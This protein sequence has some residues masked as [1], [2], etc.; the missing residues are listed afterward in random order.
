MRGI[1]S[2]VEQAIVKVIKAQLIAD[3]LGTVSVNSIT[4]GAPGDEPVYPYVH[5]GCRP[6]AHKGALI[7]D[8]T[9]EVSISLRTRHLTGRDRE[10]TT[11]VDLL[12]SVG[13]ALDF[14]DFSAQALRVNSIQVRRIGG[15]WEF[16]DSANIVNI[17]ATVIVCGSKI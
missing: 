2:D 5:V 10:A 6:A 15:S 3:N 9:T 4:L 12:D 13:Y 14:G 11:L 8:W 16:E 7:K 1:E 17:D